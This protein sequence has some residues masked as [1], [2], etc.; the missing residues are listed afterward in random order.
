MATAVLPAEIWNPETETWTTVAAQANGR[1]YHST[2]LLLPDGRVL[3]AGGGQLPGYPVT[4][5]KNAQIFSPP[6]LFKGLRP[7]ITS[8]PSTV[9][10][11][12]SFT[13]GSFDPESIRKVS[14]VRLGSQTHA[15]DQNQRFVPLNFT[16]TGGALQVDAPANSAS[17]RPATTCSSSSTERGSVGRA[18]VRLP[19]ASEDAGSD[20]PGQ[21]DRRRPSA[22]RR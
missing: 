22:A 13:V 15:F 11:G 4:N 18:M 5:Q 21:P 9:Q 19:A 20:R 10:H 3:M 6:Y 7:T 8:A 12:S 17:R 1:G 16:T 14:L 2:A